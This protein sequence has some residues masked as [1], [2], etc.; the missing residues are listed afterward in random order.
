MKKVFLLGAMVCA[1]G[2]W[3]VSCNSNVSSKDN[4][5]SNVSASEEQEYR[6]MDAADK[7]LKDSIGYS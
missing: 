5:I 4:E 2:T 1:L 7:E 6:A 3:L